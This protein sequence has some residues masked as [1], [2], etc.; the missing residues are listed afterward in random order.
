MAFTH[1]GAARREIPSPPPGAE[2]LGEVGDS[3]I[4]R[5]MRQ[6]TRIQPRAAPHLTLPLRPQGR[7]GALF[8]ASE[9]LN[10]EGIKSGEVARPARRSGYEDWRRRNAGMSRPTSSP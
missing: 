2:R 3:P 9:M 4:V 5:V 8:C 10:A 1:F 7:R 6:R